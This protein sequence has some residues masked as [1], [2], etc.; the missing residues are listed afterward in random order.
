MMRLAKKAGMKVEFAYGDAD[1][2]LT[3]PPANPSTIVEEAANVQWADFDYLLKEN[4]KRSNDAWF[5]FLG[6]YNIAS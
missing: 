4:L 3:L 6:K 5:W 1:A 2:Y